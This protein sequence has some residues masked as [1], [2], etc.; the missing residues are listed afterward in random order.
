MDQ[1]LQDFSREIGGEFLKGNGP[2]SPGGIHVTGSRHSYGMVYVPVGPW[3]V[4]IGS[5]SVHTQYGLSS[6]TQLYAT[7]ITA[8]GFRF[9]IARATFLRNLG[10]WLGFWKDVEI[11]FPEFDEA[12]VITGTDAVRLRSLFADAKL[13]EQI[14]A[15]PDFMMKVCDKP[16]PFAIGEEPYFPDNVDILLFEVLATIPDLGT[17]KAVFEVFVATMEALCRLG[18]SRREP[19][20]VEPW[21]SWGAGIPKLQ[22]PPSPSMSRGPDL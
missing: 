21:G 5:Q 14:Q 3:T 1:I 4:A 7:Y 20:G 19:S 2:F 18:T 6:S 11:G 13:R 9:S 17:L 12:F 10:R 16:W 8:D 22:R 15:Q